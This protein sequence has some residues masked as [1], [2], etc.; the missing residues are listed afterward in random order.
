MLR[1]ISLPPSASSAET[2]TTPQPLSWKEFCA[3]RVTTVWSSSRCLIRSAS[4]HKSLLFY[5]RR[6]TKY[7]ALEEW[8]QATVRHDKSIVVG[9]YARSR[10]APN[11]YPMTTWPSWPRHRKG[12]TTQPNGRLMCCH[13]GTR[14]IRCVLPRQH[15]KAGAIRARPRGTTSWR[16]VLPRR[17]RL[18][19]SRG[20][21][22]GRD[23]QGCERAESATTI[24]R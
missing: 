18:E 23:G 5:H 8:R 14:Q 19:T 7:S 11:C 4:I 15:P 6:T 20:V 2:R 1:S 12:L 10:Q 16:T 17:W 24:T 13:H 21:H 3:I 9:P 22:R